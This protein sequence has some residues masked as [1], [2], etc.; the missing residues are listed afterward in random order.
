MAPVSEGKKNVMEIIGRLAKTGYYA[1]L[2]CLILWVAH[3][4]VGAILWHW[5]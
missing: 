4:I 3:W 1:F 5:R 2:L